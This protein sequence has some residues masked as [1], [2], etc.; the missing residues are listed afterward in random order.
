ML[1]TFSFSVIG[2]FL[3][4]VHYGNNSVVSLNEIGEESKAL[5]CLTNNTNCCRSQ[6]YR[7]V[8][9]WFF[10]NSTQVLPQFMNGS[11]YRDRGHSN[12]RLHR[13]NNAMSPNGIFRC[14]I[15][16]AD[17]NNYSIYIGVHAKQNRIG[18]IIVIIDVLK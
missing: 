13:R 17:E 11:I 1:Y 6:Q 2:F 14:D 18:K 7:R 4:G 3:N 9:E 16:G 8:S 10:P 12:I 15:L 5:F